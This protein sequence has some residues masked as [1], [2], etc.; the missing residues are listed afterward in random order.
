MTP[1]A[2][3][4]LYAVTALLLFAVFPAL[5]RQ[6]GVRAAGLGA[7]LG[8]IAYATYAVASYKLAGWVL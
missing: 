8:F 4:K 7:A 5:E 3:A 6:S 2:F 1:L